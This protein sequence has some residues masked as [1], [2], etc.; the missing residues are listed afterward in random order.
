MSRFRE[1]M[2]EEVLKAELEMRRHLS[3]QL[4]GPPGP[5]L[6]PMEVIR[7]EAALPNHV[8]VYN[9]GSV[10]I[11]VT[12]EVRK[13]YAGLNSLVEATMKQYMPRIT[14]QIF[15]ENVLLEHLKK[16]DNKM[17][18]TT[19]VSGIR[20]DMNHEKGVKTVKRQLKRFEGSWLYDLKKG[21]HIGFKVRFEGSDKRYNYAAVYDGKFWH[22][23]GRT[24][25]NG[26]KTDDLVDWLIGHGVAFKSVELYLPAVEE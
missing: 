23:T 21:A 3:D 5:P 16:E 19:I 20:A 4:F 8:P 18:L 9:W 22:L 11:G 6:T 24:S 26:I 14:E 25:P 10:K 12:D 17:A 2:A 1:L 13:D 15:S 7:R